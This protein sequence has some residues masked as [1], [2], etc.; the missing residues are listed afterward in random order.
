MWQTP[1]IP[2]KLRE[3][4]KL[5]AAWVKATAHQSHSIQLPSNFGNCGGLV[6][7]KEVD[8][9]DASAAVW[10]YYGSVIRSS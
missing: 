5:F 10:N 2:Y 8:W 4:G 9:F 6:N 1:P 3:A 7:P